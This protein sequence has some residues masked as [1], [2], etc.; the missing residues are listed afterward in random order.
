MTYS[1]CFYRLRLCWSSSPEGLAPFK[2]IYL[3]EVNLTKALPHL[4]QMPPA[5]LKESFAKKPLAC[6]QLPHL[7]DL[8]LWSI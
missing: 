8:D 6:T 2:I 4:P 3:K 1:L 7:D 5:E